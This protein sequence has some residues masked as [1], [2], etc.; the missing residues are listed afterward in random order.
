MSLSDGLVLEPVGLLF[1]SDAALTALEQLRVAVFESLATLENCPE[2]DA[3][4][5]VSRR[6]R[7]DIRWALLRGDEKARDELRH[8]ETTI[9]ASDLTSVQLRE[10]RARAPE[11]FMSRPRESMGHYLAI[12]QNATI[13]ADEVLRHLR[14]ERANIPRQAFFIGVQVSSSPPGAERA[15]HRDPDAIAAALATF[16]LAGTAIVTLSLPGKS[17]Y[18]SFKTDPE[19]A[20]CLTGEA[21]GYLN[22]DRPVEHAVEVGSER[23]VAITLRFADADDRRMR[24]VTA[25]PSA[26]LTHTDQREARRQARAAARDACNASVSRAE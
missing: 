21:L 6:R 4:S 13:L 23:R 18:C 2:D 20:Y 1:R 9:P 19:T 11:S 16:S 26:P 15:P 8:A 5:P 17:G 3:L 10:L 12:Q 25:A 7:T 24:P 22:E 14:R